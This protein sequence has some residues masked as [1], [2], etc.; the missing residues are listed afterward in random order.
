MV[1]ARAVSEALVQAGHTLVPL[2]IAQD[3]C[4]L[5][6]EDSASA[7]ASGQAAIPAVGE[8]IAQSLSNLLAAEVDVLF[9]LIHGTWGEDGT[10]QG[11]CEMLDKPYVGAGATTSALS[12]DK[13]LCKAQLE[14]AGIPVA[15][16]ASVR[17]AD[18]E[19]DSV[20]SV[21]A[22]KGL[23]GP[24]FVKPS[25][26]GSSV[27]ISRVEKP[28]DLESAVEFALRFDDLVLI[29]EGVL[30]RELECSVLGYKEINASAI[31]E[32]VPGRDFYDYI[33]KYIDD[34]AGLHVP[35]D[36]EPE[37]AERIR[38]M[39]VDT[40]QAVGGWGMA[41]VDF[42]TGPDDRLVVNEL[43][44]LPGFTA[45]SMYPKLWEEVGLS[46]PALVDRLVE[47]AIERHADRRRLDDGIKDFLAGL[48]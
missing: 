13:V 35:A 23:A 38:S 24:W 18:F 41:R 29:E 11:L 34:G 22:A 14:N 12:M 15:A 10:L 30:G 44:T 2:A 28:D 47:I 40:F 16:Y 8:P 45:I 26:G 39:A 19:R 43:N 9:P 37:L 27:G 48:G 33:D 32:I 42:L 3:G 25:V 20:G 21:A 1:S 5:S 6:V 4:W 31:G 36:I 46:M 17:R 7:L